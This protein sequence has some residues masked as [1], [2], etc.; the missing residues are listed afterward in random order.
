[1]LYDYGYFREGLPL[2]VGILGY[3]LVLALEILTRVLAY[4]G[5][6]VIILVPVIWRVRKCSNES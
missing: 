5:W 1:M 2:L 6:V 3:G 4:G